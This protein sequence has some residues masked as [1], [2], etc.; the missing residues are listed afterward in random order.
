VG[1]FLSK[2]R[3]L[4]IDDEELSLKYFNL[5]LREKFDITITP[6]LA[7]AYN[8]I[9]SGET[10]DAII[11]DYRFDTP[12]EKRTGLQFL[13]DYNFDTDKMFIALCSAYDS[14]EFD[15]TELT[16]NINFFNKPIDYTVIGSN[17]DVFFK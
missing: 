5:I 4:Y 9:D 16:D 17:I 2:L 15:K 11:V 10:Y 12:G 7:Q 14:A 13:H 1:A 3:V 6:L 8:L